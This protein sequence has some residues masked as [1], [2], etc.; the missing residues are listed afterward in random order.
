MW[1]NLIEDLSRFIKYFE[2]RIFQDN[3]VYNN[4][5]VLDDCL[6]AL[7]EIVLHRVDNSVK[8]LDDKEWG[9]LRHTNRH[10]EDVTP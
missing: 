8:E 6:G 4:I 2:E 10:K 1:W 7:R 5:V 3:L 9:N